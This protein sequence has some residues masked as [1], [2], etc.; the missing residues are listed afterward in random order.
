M[1]EYIK[2]V[3]SFAVGMIVL[4]LAAFVWTV[5]TDPSE[6][7]QGS[8]RNCPLADKWA[9]A[10]WDGDDGTDAEQALGTCG[11]GAVAV[12][13]SINPYTQAWS[14]WFAGRPEISNLSALSSPQA[15]IA[16]GGVGASASASLSPSSQQ[17]AMQ[18]CPVPGWWAISVWSGDDGSD[19]GQA[20]ATCGEEAVAAAYYLDP[21]TQV[22]SRWFRDRPD[23][24]NLLALGH[25]QGLLVLG[26]GAAPSPPS[27]S[28][29]EPTESGIELRIPGVRAEVIYESRLRGPTGIATGPDG[30]LYIADWLSYRI[31]RLAS[32]GEL[33]VAVQVPRQFSSG[34]QDVA[35]DAGGTMYLATPSEILRATPS[36][37][38]ISFAS[39]HCCMGGIE[40]GPD[41]NLYFANGTT[42]E[43][44]LIRPDGTAGVV[45]AGLQRP[46]DVAF[47]PAG[48]LYV[49]E[50]GRDILRVSPDGTAS[51]FATEDF[52]PS[53]PLYIAFD[54][55]GNLYAHGNGTLFKF[56]PLGNN[57]N[58]M[59]DGE[60]PS[61]MLGWPKANPGGVVV[62]E[63]GYLYVADGPNAK[64]TRVDPDGHLEI[65][66]RG[67][68]PNGIALGADGNIYAGSS[69]DFP[70][71]AG[72]LWRITPDGEL[73]VVARFRDAPSTIA[74][75]TL[76]NVYVSLHSRVDGSRHVVR[77]AR[78]GTVE[79]FLTQAHNYGSMAAA[80]DGELY[81]SLP[82]EGNIYRVALDGTWNLFAE[83]LSTA[84]PWFFTL[85][86]GSDGTLYAADSQTGNVLRFSD[87]GV[88]SVVTNIAALV[89]P[90]NAISAAPD[91]TVFVQTG[92]I[93]YEMYKVLPDGTQEVVAS[94]VWGD[95]LGMDFDM[96]G[97]LY[98]S[99]G[100]TIERV[101]GL[102]TP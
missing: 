68:N 66:V 25:I 33:D 49:S 62:D 10:V 46:V 2:I 17:N 42:N 9:V 84:Q 43:V 3:L 44:L 67:F 16:L 100:G 11:E 90:P 36:G 24:T 51:T 97:N 88:S 78:D 53:D 1:G 61:G 30:A 73:T 70:Q 60:D 55:D 91:G 12:A 101:S 4:G 83:G 86:T 79:D 75:D 76:G 72:E 39:G 98:V 102:V 52:G 85:A 26:G 37:D 41:G 21:Q 28:T 13:Y 47:G 92:N 94:G 18:N 23:I 14:R 20:F 5:G 56:D 80:P 77:A 54:R 65:L 59:I 93:P 6:A 29:L 74:A 8:M 35:F 71:G 48:E 50:F 63:N 89:G 45:A 22:W 82:E 81:V 31:M 99:R 95:P 38:L 34:P 69:A 19:A 7:Q 15:I 58:L 57:M 27:A 40:F 64:I 32:D 96:D 87:T